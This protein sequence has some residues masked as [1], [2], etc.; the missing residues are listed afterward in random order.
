MKSKI[1]T[2]FASIYFLLILYVF[3]YNHVIDHSCTVICMDAFVD[4]LLAMPWSLVSGFA[5]DTG[6]LVIFQLLNAAILYFI[7]LGVT[8][9]IS[10]FRK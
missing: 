3:I 9:V 6:A 5:K 8:K 2:T 4:E 7:G 1:G 10:Y